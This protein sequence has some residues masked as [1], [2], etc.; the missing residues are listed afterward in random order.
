LHLPGRFGADVT[1][2]RVDKGLK[3]EGVILFK[4]GQIG[5]VNSIRFPDNLVMSL[6]GDELPVYAGDYRCE[7]WHRGTEDV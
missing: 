7:T 2:G 6:E 1:L 3:T 4:L 5:T